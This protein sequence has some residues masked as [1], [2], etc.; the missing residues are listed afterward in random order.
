MP[1]TPAGTPGGTNNPCLLINATYQGTAGWYKAELLDKD[2]SDGKDHFLPLLRNYRYNAV[3]T[4]V[5]GRGYESAEEAYKS[6]AQNLIVQIYTHSDATLTNVMY[7]GQYWLAWDPD[8]IELNKEVHSADDT[9][10]DN[11]MQIQS[12]CEDGWKITRITDDTGQPVTWLTIPDDQKQGAKNE[13]KTLRLVTT[14]NTDVADRV[15]YVHFTAGRMDASVEVTQNTLN[16]M[17]IRFY[18]ADDNELTDIFWVSTIEKKIQERKFRVKWIPKNADLSVTFAPDDYWSS[19]NVKYE[20]GGDIPAGDVKGDGI[21]EYNLKFS[22]LKNEEA[23]ADLWDYFLTYPYRTRYTF[24]LDYHGKQITKEIVIAHH[25]ELFNLS[26]Y[27]PD[28]YGMGILHWEQTFAFEV[29]TPFV[30]E[31]S[32]PHTG[33]FTMYTGSFGSFQSGFNPDGNLGKGE[34]RDFWWVVNG[35]NPTPERMLQ[36]ETVTLT[37]PES[38]LPD[39]TIILKPLRI[40]PNC[41][42]TP[43][44]GTVHIPVRNPWD[45]RWT[46]IDSYDRLPL[47]ELPRTGNFTCERLWEDVE[48]LIENV[49]FTPAHTFDPYRTEMTVKTNGS[50]GEGNAVIALRRDNTII[51]SWHIWVTAYDPNA[52]DAVMY[53]YNNMLDEPIFFMDRN[54]G[55]TANTNY[56]DQNKLKSVGL[57]YQGE[58]KDPFPPYGGIPSQGSTPSLSEH[59]KVYPANDIFK[60]EEVIPGNNSQNIMRT[61]ENP[62][63]FITSQSNPFDWYTPNTNNRWLLAQF[64]NKDNNQDITMI[65]NIYDPCP[66]GWMVPTGFTRMPHRGKLWRELGRY[67]TFYPEENVNIIPDDFGIVTGEGDFYPAAGFLNHT[68]GSYHQV[69]SNVLVNTGQFEKVSANYNYLGTLEVSVQTKGTGYKNYPYAAGINIR[70]MKIDFYNSEND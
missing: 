21:Y 1:E 2:I 10:T 54:L 42:I 64:A 47:P 14:E 36:Y 51:W 67:G 39:T 34:Y 30:A 33:L 41:Y 58:R 31:L 16:P 4:H 49:I 40:L 46:G 29:S 66:E 26:R 9:Y 68:D 69:G 53:R 45:A 12:N 35:K 52:P 7:D 27:K 32:N 43:P 5:G 37:F 63:T 17:D 15:A 19:K 22:E 20:N 18:D 3:I 44:G 57:Y 50:R 56:S 6:T 13:K 61:I 11:T 8:K 65:K 62:T 23:L 70:C 59:K 38:E 24:T 28:G 25:L 48:G 60:V 55:A